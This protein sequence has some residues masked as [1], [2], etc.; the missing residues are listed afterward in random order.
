[1]TYNSLCII[2]LGTDVKYV[3]EVIKL[4]KCQGRLYLMNIQE[5]VG[6]EQYWGIPTRETDTGFRGRRK[7]QT[8]VQYVVAS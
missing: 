5:K 3:K 2:T 1:V 8:C 4:G 6:T 7:I